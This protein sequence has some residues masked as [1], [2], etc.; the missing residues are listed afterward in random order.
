MLTS[1][2]THVCKYCCLLLRP[3]LPKILDIFN[4]Q[5]MGTTA[6]IPELLPKRPRSMPCKR[7]HIEHR[8]HSLGCRTE[9][10]WSR[11]CSLGL[12]HSCPGVSPGAPVKGAWARKSRH[13]GKLPAKTQVPRS[14]WTFCV[15]IQ[16]SPFDLYP[17]FKYIF[18]NLVQ[19]LGTRANGTLYM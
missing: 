15:Q 3:G 7:K 19:E 12:D 5:D 11:C 16:Y 2:A 9:A 14:K 6:Y 4:L 13:I 8:S 1:P 17:P 10:A 18:K